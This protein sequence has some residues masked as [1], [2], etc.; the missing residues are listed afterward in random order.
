MQIQVNGE[1]RTL[2]EGSTIADLLAELA[3]TSQGVAVE[4]NREVVPRGRHAE[5]TL[6]EGDEVEVVRAIGGGAR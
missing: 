6:A 4:V 2:A 1:S 3:L 5:H